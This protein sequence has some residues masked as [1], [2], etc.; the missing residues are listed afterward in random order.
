M[1]YDSPDAA[2]AR[3]ERSASRQSPTA[4]RR[5]FSIDILRAVAILL[6]I[7]VH[8]VDH[9]S[10]DIADPAYL[11]NLSQLFG[12]MSAPLF[13]L[14]SGL[15]FSLWLGAQK[16]AAV[17]TDEIVKYG[18]R[19]GMFVF[20]LGLVVNIFIW[21]PDATFDWDI[22][23]LIGA[24]AMILVGVRNWRPRTLIAICLVILLVSPPLRD[25]VNYPSYWRDGE[26]EYE[27]NLG[28]VLVAFFLSAYFPLLPWL[29]FP[30]IGFVLGQVFY[31]DEKEASLPL[32]LP[33]LG[34]ALLALALIGALVGPQMPDWVAKYYATG[35]PTGFYPAT[36]V[37]ILGSLGGI[38]IG[39]WIM[40]HAIDLNRRVTGTGPVLMFFRRYSYFALTAYV[41]H[42][43]VQLWPM[44]ILAWWEKKGSIDYY[45][46]KF[47]SLPTALVSA[48]VLIIVLYLFFIFLD[49]Y[50]KY[51]LEYFMRWIS[52]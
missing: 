15:S 7:Q 14:L 5:Y 32:S 46:G 22:L 33:L 41:V 27:T 18:L 44:W 4:S 36:T 10:E 8:A 16:R 23:A 31:P 35:W 39:L 51:S 26:L 42:L 45:S 13:T 3:G 49:R 12:H 37:F 50:K 21:L 9:F 43:A 19:R 48:F 29:I 40:N 1:P 11:Y 38:F 17:S 34:A 30:L 24:S 2:S 6:M 47:A 52:T 20:G 25:L 28:E